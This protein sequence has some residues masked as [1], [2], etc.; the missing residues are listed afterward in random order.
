MSTTTSSRTTRS[1]AGSRAGS[2]GN[3][4]G[5]GG[6][7]APPGPGG[8]GGPGDPGGPNDPAGQEAQGNPVAFALSP[9]H[10]NNQGLLDYST[11]TGLASYEMAVAPMSKVLYDGSKEN[12]HLFRAEL[13]RRATACG[14]DTGAGD[15]I[16]IPDAHNPLEVKDFVYQNQSLTKEDITAWANNTIVNQAS[17]RVQNNFNAVQCLSSSID[18]KMKKRILADKEDCKVGGVIIAALL[19][20]VIM[21]KSEPSGMGT[22][23]ALKQEIRTM[24]SVIQSMKIDEFN[25]H[26]NRLITTLESHQVVMPDLMDHLFA[27]YRKAADNKFRDHIEEIEHK[28]LRGEVQYL[29]YTANQLMADALAEYNLRVSDKSSPWGA[30]SEEQEEILLLKAEIKRVTADSTKKKKK[31][32]QQRSTTQGNEETSVDRDESAKFK[33]PKWKLEKPKDETETKKFKGKTYYWC[34]HHYDGGMWSLH[35]PKDCKN[36]ENKQRSDESKQDKISVNMAEESDETSEGEMQAAI[37]ILAE[38]S[39]DE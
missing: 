19:F 34:P 29:N 16:N 32:K 20:N 14:W 17:R 26:V 27:A 23:R 22:I 21:T 15:I 35:Q 39:D 1:R 37:A 6:D 9:S 11:K 4:P 38:D 18:D 8:Q 24:D 2:G 28:Y 3:P 36:R 25:D 31:K 5:A 30:L 7:G 13:T 12:T 10:I 33:I